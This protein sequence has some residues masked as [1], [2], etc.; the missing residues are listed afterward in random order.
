MLTKKFYMHY[1]SVEELDH[2]ME[3]FH[4]AGMILTETTEKGTLYKMPETQVNQLTEY[5]KGKGNKKQ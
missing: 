5:L 4:V 3:S 2:M 1:A